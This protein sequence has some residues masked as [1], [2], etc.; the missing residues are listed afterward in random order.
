MTTATD[1]TIEAPLSDLQQEINQLHAEIDRLLIE[2]R[3]KTQYNGWSNY[4]TWAVNLWL[5]NNEG[6]Y[7]TLESEMARAEEEIRQAIADDEGDGDAE[8]HSYTPENLRRIKLYVVDV[9][10]VYV[11]NVLEETKQYDPCLLTG[12]IG[13]LYSFATEQVNAREIALSICDEV[14]GTDVKVK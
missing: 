8:L 14:C 9:M 13:D 2:V 12:L 3:T 11:E 10:D 4:P 6:D 7:D 1:P 5:I